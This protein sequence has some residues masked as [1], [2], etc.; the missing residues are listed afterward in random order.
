MFNYVCCSFT[1]SWN[2]SSLGSWVVEFYQLSIAD[3]HDVTTGSSHRRWRREGRSAKT[4]RNDL[5]QLLRSCLPH[6][7][8]ISLLINVTFLLLFLILLHVHHVDRRKLILLTPLHLP[9]LLPLRHLLSS[10]VR[11]FFQPWWLGFTSS[12]D[13]TFGRKSCSV[14]LMEAFIL[15]APINRLTYRDVNGTGLLSRAWRGILV[16]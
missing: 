4:L 9:N 7:C 2:E 6:R 16:L 13:I 10:H 12:L 1:R 15:K 3:T 14:C 11:A 8:V 5:C